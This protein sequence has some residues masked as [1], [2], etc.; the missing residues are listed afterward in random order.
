MKRR[1]WHNSGQGF[2]ENSVPRRNKQHSKL[3][4]LTHVKIKE[5]SEITEK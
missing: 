3:T 2:R 4:N 5:S 1:N